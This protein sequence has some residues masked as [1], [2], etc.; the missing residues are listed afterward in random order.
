MTFGANSVTISVDSVD[1]V[2]VKI[3]QDNFSSQY[4][5]RES[6]AEYTLNCRHSR[7]AV[8]PDGS[9]YDRHNVELIHTIFATESAPEI[10][11]VA[12]VVIRNKRTDDYDDV[13]LSAE[14]VTLLLNAATITELLAWKN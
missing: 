1:K 10:S 12:Y 13:V 7:E 3:N 6:A 4:Y 11:R 8:L 9:R 2:L 5:L 14:A